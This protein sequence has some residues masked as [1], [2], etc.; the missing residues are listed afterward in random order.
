MRHLVIISRS[1]FDAPSGAA[2]SRMLN[3]ARAVRAA[4]DAQI[5]LV[6]TLELRAPDATRGRLLEDGI[7]C[8]P[9]RV[10]EKRRRFARLRERVCVRRLKR[11]M[12][13][14]LVEFVLKLQDNASVLLF[15]NMHD[16]YLE[17][18]ILLR[19]K[20]R[21]IRI[22]LEKNE[23][24]LGMALHF[25]L[26]QWNRLFDCLKGWISSPFQIINSMRHD[27]LVAGFDG[28]IAISTRLER[29]V[30]PFNANVIRI[31]I[32]MD[33][34]PYSPGGPA[35]DR[36]NLGFAGN[37]NEGKEG[38]KTFISVLHEC[39]NGDREIQLNLYGKDH[40]AAARNV[41][42]LVKRLGLS[43]MV[44]FH[45][46]LPSSAIPAAL[47]RQDLLLLPRPDTLQN[48][49]GFST[50]LASYLASGVPVLV[51]D[52]GDNR[53]Y[54]RDGENGFLIPPG[55]KIALKAKLIKILQMKDELRA[56]GQRGQETA[57]DHF[58]YRIHQANLVAMIFGN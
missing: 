19:F 54:I 49:F 27:R 51:T 26:F 40:D 2:Y 53:L 25:R 56:I 7:T 13:D 14:G 3:Y 47:A 10:D 43:G 39:V 52:V 16:Y 50:K 48:R 23:L 46:L 1:R 15:P 33:D 4:G 21:G 45:G 5:H 12:V 8:Y 41:H 6:S 32:L 22:I 37:I 38:L 30:R 57:M 34:V 20:F 11:Q 17:R 35:S 29:W 28:V 18:Q 36:F 42:R 55:D 31:P 58:H 24:E 44:L 9:S